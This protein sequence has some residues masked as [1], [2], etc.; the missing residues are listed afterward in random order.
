MED[1]APLYAEI[2]WPMC[3][4]NKTKNE[5]KKKE[6]KRAGLTQVRNLKPADRGVCVCVCFVLSTYGT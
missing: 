5:N 3:L 4:N 2:Q 1:E 6:K